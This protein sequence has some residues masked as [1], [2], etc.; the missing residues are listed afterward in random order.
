MKVYSFLFLCILLS[1]FS[2]DTK[3]G[4]TSSNTTADSLHTEEVEDTVRFE[5][6]TDST[7]FHIGNKEFEIIPSTRAAFDAVKSSMNTMDTSEA[8]RIKKQSAFVSRKGDSLLF[9]CANNEPAYL[10]NNPNSDSDDF[11]S[12]SFIQDMPEIGQWLIM[13][14]YYEAYG[15][16]FIDKTTGESTELYGMPVVS[17]DKKYIITFNQDLEAGFTFNGIQLFEMKDSKPVLLGAKELNSWGPDNVKWKDSNTLFVQQA[18]SK[19]DEGE[20]D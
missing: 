2:C 13:G 6:V 12:Y 10:I 16:V 7:S 4:E 11:A 15:Y 1:M 8:K 20:Q 9:K 14:S 3:N 17:P 19:F 5:G 18:F